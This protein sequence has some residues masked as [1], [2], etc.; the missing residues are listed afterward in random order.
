M[1]SHQIYQRIHRWLTVFERARPK[2]EEPPG[3]NADVD[4]ILYG[5]GR[6]GSHLADRLTQTR[7]GV[8]AV[9]FDPHTVATAAREGMNTVFGSAE[10]IHLLEALP[11]T[12]ARYVISTIPTRETNLTLLHNLRHHHYDG[13]VAL[14]AHTRHD[15]DQLRAAGADTVL[16]PFATA[17]TATSDALR[18]LLSTDHDPGHGMDLDHDAPR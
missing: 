14:T 6:F 13:T 2:P 12:H 10:D 15:A 8:L 9:D 7:H 11:L 4:V 16:E 5:L 3:Q 17:A 18:D 1:Y